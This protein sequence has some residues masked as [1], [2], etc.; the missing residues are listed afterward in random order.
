MITAEQ[1]PFDEIVET[2]QDSQR[3][4]I[5]GC[6][7]CVTVCMAGGEKEGQKNT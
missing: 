3:L 2:I 7:T 1:K 4:L 6:G 5:L